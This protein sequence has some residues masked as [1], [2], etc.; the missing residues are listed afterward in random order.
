MAFVAFRA[1]RTDETLPSSG[2]CHLVE[3]LAL[4]T[5]YPRSLEFNG[6]V[7]AITTSFWALGPRERVFEFLREL[8]SS[9]GALPLERLE[10][11]RR[12]L[13]TE[14]SR[15]ETHPVEGTLNLRFGARGPGLRGLDEL[16]L[17]RL[18]ADDVVRWSAERYTRGNA[19]AFLTGEPPDDLAWNLPP[20]GDRIA[21][22]APEPIPYLDLPAVHI[23]GTVGMVVVAFV[24]ERSTDLRVITSIAERRARQ[25]LR[26]ALGVTYEVSWS[27]DPLTRDVAHVT[28]WA[29][30]LPENANEVARELVAVLDELSANGPTEDELEREVEEG[31]EWHTDHEN[32]S[33]DLGYR[34]VQELLEAP[35]QTDDELN[36]EI[37]AVTPSSAAA[38]LA[39]GL[40]DA[41]LVLPLGTRPPDARFSTYPVSS[42]GRVSGR[43]LALRGLNIGRAARR[44]RLVLGD[45]GVSLV[46]PDDDAIT[47]RFDECVAVERWAGGAR[48]LWSA[49]GFRL[50]IQP[51]AWR[52]GDVVVRTIDE[53][54]PAELVV[55]MELEV[56]ERTAEVDALADEKVK[57]GWMT[58][59]EL[60]TLPS[61]L[62][63]GE[64]VVTLAQG[65]KGWRFGM[66]ALTDRRLLFLYVDE[67]I[68]ETEL[69]SISSVAVA[70]ETWRSTPALTL[71]TPAG[72]L[73]YTDFM[74]DRLT[75]LAEALRSRIEAS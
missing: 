16:G 56:E 63:P 64:R 62:A 41:L 1:G 43:T 61:V 8:A 50:E 40:E 52:D 11:E 70:P 24:A 42:P 7:D 14:A 18:S 4:P 47:V 6:T 75:E 3:H 9:L 31:R 29:D 53:R 67:L 74:E 12:I 32:T 71:E 37:A 49:D 13:M 72:A 33:A 19:V 38:A 51:E 58:S 17:H 54:L 55:P 10:T 5:D 23:G 57:R 27:Y 28:I 20:P 26:Y 59:D 44:T 65:S 66:L 30:S 39:A 73:R 21:P 22:P 45:D 46:W 35:F 48:A 36:A 69:S 2:V 15:A 68:E 34:V 25:R 60:K